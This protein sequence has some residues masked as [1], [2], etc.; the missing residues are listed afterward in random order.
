MKK[1]LEEQLLFARKVLQV[2][3]QLDI[4]EELFWNFDVEMPVFYVKCSDVFAWGTA[5]LEKLTPDN[6]PG[7]LAAYLDIQ[8]VAGGVE[9]ATYCTDLFVARIRKMRP[10][11]ASYPKEPKLWP[12][13]DMVGPERE[14][15]LGNP[16][17]HPGTL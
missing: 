13:F 16:K 11:G 5:D 9:A 4:H 10:Q 7:L 2:F 12:L 8:S 15:R 1:D 3:S 14:V 17:K 6:L